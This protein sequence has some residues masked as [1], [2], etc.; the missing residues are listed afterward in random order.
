[1]F[2]FY[3]IF[4]VNQDMIVSGQIMSKYLLIILPVT[5]FLNNIQ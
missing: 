2:L 5:F 4:Y 1:M 3:D